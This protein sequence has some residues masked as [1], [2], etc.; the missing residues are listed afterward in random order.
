MKLK[1]KNFINKVRKF[2]NL[3]FKKI[4][5]SFVAVF[6]ALV[7]FCVPVSALNDFVSIPVWSGLY[8]TNCSIREG[9]NWSTNEWGVV[10]ETVPFDR[11]YDIPIGNRKGYNGLTYSKLDKSYELQNKY[12]MT[13][14]QILNNDNIVLQKNKTYKV[15]FTLFF[16]MATTK[17]ITTD[18]LKFAFW[19]IYDNSS[20]PYLNFYDDNVIEWRSSY[21]PILGGYI[22][23]HTFYL[24]ND[25]GRDI[26][27]THIRFA[28]RF[29]STL[30]LWNGNSWGFYDK[31]TIE[32]SQFTIK[33]GQLYFEGGLKSLKNLFG[34]V[35]DNS[36]FLYDLVQFS[37]SL[38]VCAIIVGFIPS[39]V[40]S[41][42]HSHHNS[43]KKSKKG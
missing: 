29:K 30:K 1:F 38:G 13:T 4:S 21:D 41:Y 39:V 19:D 11:F 28:L 2:F 8:P 18:F 33:P 32:E 15:T 23:K 26:N 31:I 27:P 20:N 37:I 16:E 22:S 7:I 43:S 40:S 12:L 36:S 42:T 17:V 6:S 9:N 25:Y 35:F 5:F 14:F 3:N 10:F 34:K 24:K